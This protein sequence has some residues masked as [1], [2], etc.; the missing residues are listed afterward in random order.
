[1]RHYSEAAARACARDLRR[2]YSGEWIVTS[3]ESVVY[4]RGGSRCRPVASSGSR[5]SSSRSQDRRGGSRSRP[6]ARPAAP[7]SGCLPLIVT[8]AGLALCSLSALLA[9]LL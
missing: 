7:S 9:V 6:V 8:V 3:V 2:R 1:M 4:R 5:G